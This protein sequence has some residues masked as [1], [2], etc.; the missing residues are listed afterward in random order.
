M[1]RKHKR[2]L[3]NTVA[4]LESF[5]NSLTPFE[6]I[7]L[8]EFAE[9]YIYLPSNNASPGLINLDLTPYLRKPLKCLTPGNGIKKVVVMGSIQWGKSTLGLIFMLGVLLLAPGNFMIV[10][11]RTRDA[12]EFANERFMSIIKSSKIFHK[13]IDFNKRNSNNKIAKKNFGTC[14]YFFNGSNSA[15]NFKS[16]PCMYTYADETTGFEKNIKGEGDPLELL[17]GRTTTYVHNKKQCETSSPSDENCS[18]YKNYMKG[19]QEILKVPC[20][21]CGG[22]QH[23]DFF[24]GFK[25]ELDEFNRYIEDSAYYQCEFCDYKIR[26]KDKYDMLLK[27][28]WE[29]LNPS[30][31]YPS[32][33]ISGL[34]TNFMHFNLIARKYIEALEDKTKMVVFVNTYLGDIYKEDTLEVNYK[35]MYEKSKKSEINENVIDA[36]IVKMTAAVDVQSNRVALDIKGWGESEEC[37]TVYY[38]EIHGDDTSE[39]LEEVKKIVDTN[40][41]HPSGQT[42]NVEKCAIDCGHRTQEVYNFIAKN[43]NKYVA[44]MGSRHNQKT[45]FAAA[46]KQDLI[47][48]N[49]YKIGAIDL[50][51]IGTEI[52]KEE[53]FF[54][55]K[56]YLE[57][58][59]E[60]SGSKR[61]HFNKDLDERYFRMLTAEE[62]QDKLVKGYTVQEWKKIYRDNES[63]DTFVYNYAIA[64]GLLRIELISNEVYKNIYRSMYGTFGMTE[65][66]IKKVTIKETNKKNINK[67]Q[68]PK[69]F[70]KTGFSRY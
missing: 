68:N 25:Y 50:H 3:F 28:E 5:K 9:K 1:K 8:D 54:R 56:K 33:R 23:M 52:A 69:N 7:E 15:T 60:K 20:P 22:M 14:S 67:Y 31:E 4:F 42:I 18:I 63:L 24:L 17:N 39:L 40:F 35:L 19:T 45:L 16:K 64:K 13:L 59:E 29:A 46:K 11:P 38:K 6:Q 44:I 47:F 12:E 51:M 48:K 49:N 53:L 55:F 41:I 32:F 27:C 43:P 57:D 58:D 34:N 30:G 21:C 66:E 2:N 36:R 61:L 37:F 70:H 62:R 10:L 65:E 26:N